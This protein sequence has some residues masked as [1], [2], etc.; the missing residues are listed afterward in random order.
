MLHL[1]VKIM[2][3]AK[4]AAGLGDASRDKSGRKALP[5]LLGLSC[6]LSPVKVEGISVLQEEQKLLGRIHRINV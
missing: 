2:S 6:R 3:H 1:Y 5:V 4:F